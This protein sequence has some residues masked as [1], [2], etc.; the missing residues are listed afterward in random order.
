MTEKSNLFQETIFKVAP[1][2]C[3]L[4]AGYIWTSQAF[5]NAKEHD[6]ILERIE[7][8]DK[9]V[10]QHDIELAVLASKDVAKGKTQ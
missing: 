8:L 6:A 3:F 10:H 5:Q 1:S 7:N 9:R 2:V 4:L